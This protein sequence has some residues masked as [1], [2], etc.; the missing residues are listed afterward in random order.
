MFS[1][2]WLAPFTPQMSDYAA[3]EHA[4]EVATSSLALWLQTGFFP[5]GS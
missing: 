1:I 4:K 5:R 2:Y 3:V